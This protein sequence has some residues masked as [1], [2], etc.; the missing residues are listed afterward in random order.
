MTSPRRYY[1]PG[2]RLWLA[3]RFYRLPLDVLA[4]NVSALDVLELDVSG[5]DASAEKA[6]VITEKQRVIFLNQSAHAAG[7]RYGV[8]VTTAQLL[9]NCETHTRDKQK[10]VAALN[11]LSAQLYQFTPH[12]ETYYCQ[13]LPHAGLLLEIS[14]CL[15]LFSGV[16]A[17]LAQIITYLQ[18]TPYRCEYGFAHTAKGAWLLSFQPIELSDNTVGNIT[19]NE[20][21]EFFCERLK[22][23]PIHLLHDFPTVIDA[24]K[25]TGFKTLG[26]ITRQI[27]VQKISAIKKRFGLQFTQTICDI[28]AIEQDLQQGS[29]FA[30]P[31]TTYKPVEFFSENIQFDYPI[32]LS[33]Q[34]HY[35]I[36]NLLQNL[37]QYLRKRQLACQ[38][39]EWTFSDI[40][41][42]Q[43]L[44]SVHCDSAESHWQLL[45]DLTLIQLDNRELP[46]AVDSLT[47]TCR[48][49][50][51]VQNQSHTLAF[52]HSRKSRAGA[53]SFAI[54][55]AKL[56][57]RLG[58]A[59]I[60]KL[61]Y[62]DALLP[63]TSHATLSLNQT[64]N[65]HLPDIH[66]K[67]LR[68]TWLLPAPV[69]IEQRKQGLYW[70]GP[71]TLLAGPERIR[72]TWWET[73][74]ARDYFVAQR[75]DNVR[76]WVFLDLHKKTWHV[77]GI[78]G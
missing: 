42:N 10:E 59:A 11:E 76:L 55:M 30:K 51:L 22:N 1:R 38:H 52:D 65:Q 73:P 5:V 74:T 20:T 8:D 72:G 12:I 61:S 35:P 69:N 26:D 77:H 46:F 2:S 64:C 67:A 45:Y 29:L 18:T 13:H 43:F 49:A 31:L 44:L 39:I 14:S 15:K 48:D 53:R 40:Y 68:P 56:K 34:L 16:R 27:D 7:V 71:L 9:S 60:F 17:L 50:S 78:F 75:H 41:H 70:Q 24:L 33:D 66:K 36:E 58:D 3:L 23:L 32:S 37:S 28:F 4:L 19:G 57:A 62:R 47:L 6:I 21:K 54:T 25:K 63:E